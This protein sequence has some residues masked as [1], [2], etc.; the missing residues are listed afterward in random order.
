VF[1]DVRPGRGAEA[2][3]SEPVFSDICTQKRP[4]TVLLNEAVN[5]EE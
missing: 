5:L 4:V 3:L 1:G 2:G